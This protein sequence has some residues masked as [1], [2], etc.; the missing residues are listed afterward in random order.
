VN[1]TNTKIAPVEIIESEFPVR[2]HRFALI[3]DSGGA[4]EHRGGLGF[5]RDY[6]L[7][8][9]TARFSLRSTKHANPPHGM[10]GGA[11]GRGGR[12]VAYAGTSQE[13]E[14]PTR[15]GDLPI[16]RGDRVRLETPGG[17]GYGA[18]PEV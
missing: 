7:L 1:H 18:A 9:E 14:L 3:R 2:I 5:V 11:N 13:R 12:C 10:Q 6:E 15:Y 8:G 17:G 16:S 4:G